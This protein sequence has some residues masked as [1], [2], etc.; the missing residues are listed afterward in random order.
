M[1]NLKGGASHG[2]GAPRQTGG[3][4]K[5]VRLGS[6]KKRRGSGSRRVHSKKQK[7]AGG[8]GPAHK[9]SGGGC[10]PCH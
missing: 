4:S 1:A 9:I 5:R 10:G 6:Q 7:G 3:K 8:G 2:C